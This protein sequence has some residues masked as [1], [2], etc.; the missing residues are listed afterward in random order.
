MPVFGRRYS[1][2][3]FEHSRKMGRG[4]I[5][6]RITD[7]GYAELLLCQELFCCLAPDPVMIFEGGAVI[8]LPE[9]TR[10]IASVDEQG[11]R[12]LSEREFLRE[13]FFNITFCRFSQCTCR[14]GLVRLLEAG[15]FLL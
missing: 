8:E 10:E 4:N 15:F 3:V 11:A 9:H 14:T 1:D 2:V 5:T 6:D 13:V 7:I 12:E